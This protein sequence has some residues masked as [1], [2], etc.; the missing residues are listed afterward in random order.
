MNRAM[1]TSSERPRVLARQRACAKFI[2]LGEH[3]VV[4]G[5]P[6]IAL[7]LRGASTTVTVEDGVGRARLFTDATDDAASLAQRLLAT[8]L[9]TFGIDPERAP[10]SIRACSSIPMSQ[11]L[12]SSASFAVALVGALSRAASRE[13]STGERIDYAHD[14]EKQVHGRPSGIDTHVVALERPVWFVRDEPIEFLDPISEL[15]FVLASSGGPRSTGYAIEKVM[16][17]KRSSP[18]EFERLCRE[19]SD[20]ARQGKTALQRGDVRWLG[21]LMDR[22]HDLLRTLSVS[23]PALDCLVE[24]ARSAGAHGAKLTGAGL[25]GF[26]VALVPEGEEKSIV[27]AFRSCGASFVFYTVEKPAPGVGWR[28]SPSRNENAAG[29]KKGGVR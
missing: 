22:N 18:L 21:S 26:V 12:G 8:A 15:H 7:P 23:T 24:A 2:L 25:G 29:E 13:L 9:D 1:D 17:R 11:G 4:H 14:L 10:W 3:F 19:A 27:E 28:P 5:A 16:E 6:A 20:L